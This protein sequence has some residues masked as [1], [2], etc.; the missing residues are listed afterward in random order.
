MLTGHVLYG[1]VFHMMSANECPILSPPRWESD[2]HSYALT[3]IEMDA[4]QSSRGGTEQDQ[5]AFRRT[6]A[7]ESISGDASD[8]HAGE[9]TYGLPLLSVE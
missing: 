1:P 8:H 5:N 9:V 2:R 4:Y 6:K 7:Q 3:L